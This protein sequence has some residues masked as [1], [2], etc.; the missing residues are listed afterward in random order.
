MTLEHV[1]IW[2][3][4]LEKMKEYYIKYFLATPNNKYTNTATMILCG[5]ICSSKKYVQIK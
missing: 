5:S 4:Q 1:A 3:A 2:T